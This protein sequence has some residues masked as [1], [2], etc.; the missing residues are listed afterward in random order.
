MMTMKRPAR[1]FTLI[2]MMIVVAVMGILA[3]IA[4]PSYTAQIQ[5]SK[6]SDAK[7]ALQEMAQLQESYFLRNLSYAS[8]LT[9]LV[10]PSTSPNGQ[11]TLSFTALDAGGSTCDGTNVDPCT[12]FTLTATAASGTPQANDSAC[13]A[14]TLTNRGVKAATDSSNAVSTVC[15]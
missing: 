3:A 8:S 11:Y 15:W 9:Q 12:T 14:L 5:R 13:K 4:Y 1:G 6:R 7:V 2:E 10:Y